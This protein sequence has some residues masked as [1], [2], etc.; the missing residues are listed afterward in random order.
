MNRTVCFL[1]HNVLTKQHRKG[2]FSIRYVLTR[3]N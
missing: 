2:V 3:A 1:T